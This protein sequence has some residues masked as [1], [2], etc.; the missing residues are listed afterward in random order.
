MLRKE[1]FSMNMWNRLNSMGKK[2][3]NMGGRDARGRDNFC[4]QGGTE[5]RGEVLVMRAQGRI[6]RL[7][8]KENH[9]DY[10]SRYIFTKRRVRGTI[11]HAGKKRGPQVRT[12]SNNPRVK[13]NNMTSR[14]K[15]EKG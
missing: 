2:R 11:P 6:E 12:V 9:L 8:K 3:K 1:N 14:V 13:K 7:E 4:I 15:S 10:R 5:H